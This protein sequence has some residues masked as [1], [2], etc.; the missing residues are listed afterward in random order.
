MDQTMTDHETVQL[1][2][3]ML[4]QEAGRNNALAAAVV[5]I[6]A[7]L[8]DNPEVG[9]A[10]YAALEKQ[11]SDHLATTQNPVYMDGFERARV[12]VYAALTPG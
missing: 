5:G 2:A 11:Y 10:V 8:Q 12:L 1:M 7:A 9:G 6:L 4:A 3:R